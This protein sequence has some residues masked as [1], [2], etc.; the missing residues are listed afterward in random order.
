MDDHNFKV[1][2]KL[3]DDLSETQRFFVLQEIK[4]LQDKLK[5]IT[6]DDVTYY[7]EPPIHGYDDFGA[8]TFFSVR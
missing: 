2:V 8:V 5:I 1:V 6:V 3:R 7:K 4:A